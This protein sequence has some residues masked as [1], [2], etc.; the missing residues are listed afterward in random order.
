M[1]TE[2]M[3]QLFQEMITELMTLPDATGMRRCAGFFM[4]FRSLDTLR[5]QIDA[6]KAKWDTERLALLK[7]ISDLRAEL[8]NR[9]DVRDGGN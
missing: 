4:I 2:S 5:Q 8:I 6:E 7:T 9:E 3:D 1:T